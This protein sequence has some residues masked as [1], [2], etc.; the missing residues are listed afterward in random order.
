MPAAM[1][2]A[3]LLAMSPPAL[4][5]LLLG[6]SLGSGGQQAAWGPAGLAEG[7][8]GLV[9]GSYPSV[10]A[11]ASCLYVPAWL[12]AAGAAAWAGH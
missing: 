2:A 10:Y 12:L 8:Q 11:A 3:V 9:C 1:R 6:L 5:V 7:A 4:A